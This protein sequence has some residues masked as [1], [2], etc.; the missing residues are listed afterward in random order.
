MSKTGKRITIKAAKEIGETNGYSQVIVVAWDKETNTTSVTT[1]G[2]SLTDCEQAA[3][4]G[5]FVKK[6]LGWPNHLTD[7]KPARV[8]RRDK[9]QSKNE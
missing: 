9:N 1:W 5:N 3:I 2:K 7:A 4:G 8:K 6:A